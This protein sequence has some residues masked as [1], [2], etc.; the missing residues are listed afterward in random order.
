MKHLIWAGVLAVAAAMFGGA[1][2]TVRNAAAAPGTGTICN[3]KV[4]DTVTKTCVAFVNVPR[5]RCTGTVTYTRDP[6][7]GRWVSTR[8]CKTNLCN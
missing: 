7:T 3:D 8:S 5:Y 6:A 2:G 4:C 1:T